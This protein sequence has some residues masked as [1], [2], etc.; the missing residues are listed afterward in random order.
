MKMFIK[1]LHREERLNALEVILGFGL[2]GACL[3]SGLPVKQTKFPGG[4]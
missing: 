2:A 1:F 4:K 3:E